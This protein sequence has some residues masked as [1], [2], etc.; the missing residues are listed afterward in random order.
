MPGAHECTHGSPPASVTAASTHSRC[1]D[2]SGGST[3][4]CRPKP[5][6][7]GT[8]A[9]STAASAGSSTWTTSRSGA[10]HPAA[11][12]GHVVAHALGQRLRELAA[13][14]VVGRAPCRRAASRRWR[15]ASTGPATW[16]LN[17]AGAALR[18]LLERVEVLGEQAAG[19]AVVDARGVGEPPARRAAGRR[20]GRRP[21]PARGRSSRGG[22]AAGQLG[23]VRQVGQL[24]EH[25]AHGLGVVAVVVARA[26][27]RRRWRASRGS[28]PTAVRAVAVI[29][30]EPTTRVP[31]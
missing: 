7:V 1:S 11:Y 16:T 4:R 24:A 8:W 12:V 17:G 3:A 30:A 26:W 20:R 18:L 6:A 28:T 31:S 14:A 21:R 5:D 2:A 10:G 15:P 19:A 27:T 22:A 29:V 13:G 25:D 9:P 23:Q